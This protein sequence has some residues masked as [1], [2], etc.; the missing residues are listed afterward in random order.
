MIA[1]I[2]TYTY[3]LSNEWNE[4]NVNIVVYCYDCR[5][6]RVIKQVIDAKK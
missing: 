1:N 3:T 6:A 2:K 5:D 4:D